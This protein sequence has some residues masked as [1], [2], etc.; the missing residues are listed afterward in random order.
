[1][2]GAFLLFQAELIIGKRI[3]PWFGGTSAV[4]ITC[5]LFFQ[6]L[7]LAGYWYAHVLNRSRTR[8]QGTIHRLLLVASILILLGQFL[9]WH[10]PLVLDSSWKPHAH[11]DPV[12]QVVVLL[13]ISVGLPLFVLASTAPIL[14]SWWR[15]IYLHRSPYSL[16]AVSNFG[17]FLGLISYPLLVEPFLRLNTQAWLWTWTY[18]AFLF[19]CCYCTFRAY[20]AHDCAV[21]RVQESEQELGIV[22]NQRPRASVLALWLGLAGCASALLLSTTNQL[23]K[24]IAS[25]PLLWIVPLA[26]YLLTFTICFES[27]NRYSRKWSHPAFG[28]AV[29]MTPFVLVSA[30]TGRNILL[31]VVICS[32]VL[33]V[34]CMACHGELAR[35]K[36]APRQLTLFYLMVG[37]G[38]VV[39]GLFVGLAAP[40]V[41]R[42]YWEYEISLWIAA[43][44]FL[45]VLYRDRGSWLYST[46][47]KPCMLLVGT[48]AL[49]PESMAF[50]LGILI[51][52]LPYAIVAA[53]ALLL[54][55]RIERKLESEHNR[56]AILTGSCS[57]ALLVLGCVLFVVG[58]AP[59][60]EIVALRNFYGALTVEHKNPNSPSLEA[61]A[62]ISG[63]IMHGFEFRAPINRLT[64]TTY[65]AR[66]SGV[67][68][69][70][71]NRAF[72]DRSAPAPRG[73]RIGV[74]GLGVGTIA[75]YGRSGDYI[76]FYEINPQVVQLAS[77]T[78]YFQYLSLCPAK[79]DIV[80]GDARLSLEQE[81][82]HGLRQDFDLLAIDAFTG[83]A[84]PVH[85]LT[86]EAFRLYFQHLKNPRGVLAVHVT[87]K[88]LDLRGVVAAAAERLGLASLWVHS[89]GNGRISYM[90]DWV[91][92]S[93]DHEIIDSL[94]RVTKHASTLQVSESHMW[95]DDYSNLFVAV[96]P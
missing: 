7:L 55:L 74:V 48:A 50:A 31:Q 14:Q 21:G 34:G 8:T 43:F 5:M 65:F 39:G 2:L 38:G 19:G 16:Y 90:N 25:V 62:L 91:L 88:V 15:R 17:S 32:F 10:T 35:L 58:R 61:Y 85:L 54:L 52:T 46:T 94:V 24:S 95:T 42:G 45:L 66:D 82:D 76:R 73:L 33:F 49:L 71:N 67:G 29:L 18:V 1:L 27:E 40:Y 60:D 51:P 30:R 6:L 4:W 75:A 96:A 28:L 64:P 22:Q 53:F 70:I 9:R 83:D 56:T 81:L 92:V 89:N 37:A 36:P 57:F 63:G 78:R 72:F 93:R 26:L 68:L 13:A 86:E 12:L 87:N 77:D 3:L 44:L 11:G 41:F 84:I 47:F 79:I 20:G 59:R 23:C 69:I 80:L